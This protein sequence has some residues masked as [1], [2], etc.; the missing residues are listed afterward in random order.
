MNRSR[1]TASLSALFM[2]ITVSVGLSGC[3]GIL[4]S[5]APPVTEWWLEPVTPGRPVDRGGETLVLNLAVVPGLDSDRILN[6]GPQARLN[7]YAG[8]HWPEHLPEVLGSVLAR[9]FEQGGW[10]AV[11]LGNR[12]RSED[13]CLLNLETR[14][15][16]GRVNQDN[17]T[18]RVEVRFEGS[19][20]C[21]STQQPVSTRQDISVPEN[22]MGTIVAAFQ[23]ALGQ[24]VEELTAAMA[25]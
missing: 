20:D 11:R 1:R 25:P 12:A 22:R 21:G 7:H 18:Q 19:L 10:R 9:S 23:T 8:A 13:E 2:V 4:E 5:D 14:A 3:S 15:F 17:V 16:Y 6:L 24:G